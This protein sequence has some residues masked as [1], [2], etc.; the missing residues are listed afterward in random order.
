LVFN[1]GGSPSINF[2]RSLRKSPEKFYIVGVDYDKYYLQRSTDYLDNKY[3]I[4]S[5]E[6]ESYFDIINSII[7]KEKIDFVHIQNDFEL[8]FI[9]NNRDKLTHVKMFIPSV[10]TI[11]A[12]IDK[13]ESYLIWSKNKIPQPK[14]VLLKSVDDLKHILKECGKIWIRCTK[15]AGGKGS[16]PTDNFDLA[17]SWIECGEGWGKYTAA[18]CLTKD[19]VTWMSIWNDGK[20]MVAQGRKRA[21]WELSK[22]S[23][24]G[25]SGATG[26]GVT[27]SDSI[28]DKIALD[29]ILAIDK[30]PNGIYSVD[31]TYD[32]NGVPN[33]TE[34]NI[35]RFFTT[36]HFFTEAGL[37]MPYIYVK[38]AF[39]EF[40]NEKII[41][42]LPPNLVWI[43]GMDFLP[44]LTT[45]EEINKYE[46]KL[47]WAKQNKGY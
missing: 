8:Q 40:T 43:R 41:N 14:T 11:N 38:I 36:H 33:P 7:K 17:K 44:V 39:N 35:G 30:K 5:F 42:P 16:L 6:D 4:P 20:L 27:I 23:V 24:S 25:V 12:C 18:E 32:K 45:M 21:Y 9:A 26:A 15:G 29:A 31:M 47:Q 1:A 19:T 28:V 22:L 37:N 3:L 46:E 13:N 2:I 34:I 10:E